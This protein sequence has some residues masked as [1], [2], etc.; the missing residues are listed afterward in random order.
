MPVS[1]RFCAEDAVDQADGREVLHAVEA[2][3]LQLAQEHRHD[4]E[5][6]GAADAR[7]HRRVAHD[8]QHLA[9]HVDDDGVGVAVGQEAGEAAAAGHA[10]AAGVVDDDQV[11]AAALGELRRDARCRRRRR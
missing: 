9:R 4:P 2:H 11:D 8:R 6:I 1:S 5:R 10:E 7:E 3:G